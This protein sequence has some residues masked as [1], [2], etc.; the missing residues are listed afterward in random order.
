MKFILFIAATCLAA[1]AARAG[2]DALLTYLTAQP[3]YSSEKDISPE[4]VTA[5][6]REF[7]SARTI[8]LRKAFL[9]E[10]ACDRRVLVKRIPKEGPPIDEPAIVPQPS[11]FLFT[12]RLFQNTPSPLNGKRQETIR[13]DG[14]HVLKERQMKWTGATIPTGN[15]SQFYSISLEAGLQVSD[16]TLQHV[17]TLV[18]EHGKK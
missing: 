8:T 15:K 10:S 2:E 16:K 1:S 11:G 4:L 7:P 5:L 17:I 6:R 12:I 3:F 13:L 9:I 14:M 18:S